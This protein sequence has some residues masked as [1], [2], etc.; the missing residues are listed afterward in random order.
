MSDTA[1]TATTASAPAAP[2][3]STG[4][5]VAKAAY[6]GAATFGR[7]QTT[8][9]A[10]VACVIALI[11][12][13]V[14]RAKLR[15]PNTSKAT[16]TITSVGSTAQ[17]T[18]NGTTT[19]TSSVSISYT[20]AAGHT[21][22]AAGLTLTGRTKPV[23]GQTLTVYYNPTQPTDVKIES[24]PRAVGW[25]LIGGAFLVAAF[26][27]GVAVLARKSKVFAAVD[28]AAGAASLFRSL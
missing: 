6:S 17:S 26:G 21:L 16:A 25:G 28:G 23:A 2:A 11:M 27:I 20:T 13:V 3:E 14:G 22:T 19:Y 7:I 4:T 5:K 8:I 10:V 18:L 24:S 15:D 1:A 12:V 9:G